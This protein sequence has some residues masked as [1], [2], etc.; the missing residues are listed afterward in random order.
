[1]T[2]SALHSRA[3]AAVLSLA[4]AGVTV[5]GR[6]GRRPTVTALA[7][8]LRATA[9]VLAIAVIRA[10]VTITTSLLLTSGGVNAPGRWRPCLAVA[11]SGLGF[12]EIA[13]ISAGLLLTSGKLTAPGRW[14]PCLTVTA[15]G[16]GFR[17]IRVLLTSG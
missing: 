8:H 1:M 7:P 3:I 2:A 17:A 13:G 12:R 6:G 9:T 16:L 5:A 10:F 11:A 14:R 4:S 15:S